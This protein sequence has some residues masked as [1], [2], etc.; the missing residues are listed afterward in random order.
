[1]RKSSL[2][3]CSSPQSVL[4]TRDTASVRGRRQATHDVVKYQSTSPRAEGSGINPSS[5]RKAQFSRMEGARSAA[6]L[7]RNTTQ[8]VLQQAMDAKSSPQVRPEAV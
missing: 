8:F 4:Q 3:D 5:N 1:M 6:T 7:P 2:L